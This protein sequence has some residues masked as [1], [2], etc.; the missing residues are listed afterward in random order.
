MFLEIDIEMIDTCLL[1]DRL[2]RYSTM[3]FPSLFHVQEYYYGI[4][5]AGFQALII[6]LGSW[7]TSFHACYQS[8]SKP[9]T[10]W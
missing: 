10:K 3:C 6:S 4:F 8:K 9:Y 7:I 5:E 2:V 1:R